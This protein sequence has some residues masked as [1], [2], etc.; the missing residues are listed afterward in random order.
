M[1]GQWKTLK[2]RHKHSFRWIE[3][4]YAKNIN[5]IHFSFDIDSLDSSIVPGTGT[6]VKDGLA[7]SEGKK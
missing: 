3:A 5:N 6:P 1:Y 2:K 4:L 7:F